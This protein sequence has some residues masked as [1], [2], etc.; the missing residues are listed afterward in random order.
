MAGAGSGYENRMSAARPEGR[1][2]TVVAEF[3]SPGEARAAIE[4]LENH[5]I[6]GLEVAVLDGQGEGRRQPA[7]RRAVKHVGGRVAKGIVIGALI[8]AAVVGLVGLVV[9]AAAGW[10]AAAVLALMLAGIGFGAVVGAF[11]SVERGVGL[12]EDWE[13]TFQ[14]PAD[15][16]TFTRIAVYTKAESDTTRAREVLEDHRPLA[17]QSSVETRATS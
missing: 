1:Q 12:S 15:V 9:V 3:G 5:G 14:R 17:V 8:G 7:D 13:K 2:P 10:P 6:D 4:A 11:W 16:A